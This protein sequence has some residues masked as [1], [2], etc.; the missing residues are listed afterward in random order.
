MFVIRG[1]RAGADLCHAAFEHHMFQL[2]LMTHVFIMALM[3]A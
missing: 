2:A 3:D 1:V